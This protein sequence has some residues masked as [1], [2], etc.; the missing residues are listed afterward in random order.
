MHYFRSMLPDIFQIL[1]VPEPA[2][3]WHLCWGECK[4]PKDW[5][6]HLYSHDG[7]KVYLCVFGPRFFRE[8]DG[9]WEMARPPKFEPLRD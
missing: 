6:S 7:Y 9:K 8:K 3:V 2:P 5:V 1:P 4:P